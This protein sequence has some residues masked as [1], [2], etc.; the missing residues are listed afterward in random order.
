MTRFI[1]A[2]TLGLTVTISGCATVGR[3]FDTTHTAEV[4]KGQ[5]QSQNRAWFGQ[6]WVVQP[7]TVHPMGCT[8][9]WNYA[10]A[11]STA[12]IH[13]TTDVLIV[14]FDASGKI[15]DHAYQRLEDK[16]AFRFLFRARASSRKTMA[17]IG[18][19]T[20]AIYAS[21]GARGPSDPTDRC[22]NGPADPRSRCPH[23]R[24]RWW[25]T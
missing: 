2:L 17:P 3:T 21:H 1:F 4:Q 16:T 18:I 6:P 23:P 10:Y 12:G 11:H 8:A 14:D 25:R 20:G 19:P 7:I 13:T 22:R 9:R 15:C 5:D 24:H